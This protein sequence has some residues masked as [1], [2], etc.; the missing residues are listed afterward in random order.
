MPPS[1]DSA[2]VQLFS[3]PVP[4]PNFPCC[5][6][7]LHSVPL[8]VPLVKWLCNVFF[9]LP[10][11]LTHFPPLLHVSY[12]SYVP[13]ESS[14]G[15]SSLGVSLPQ[16]GLPVGWLQ[17]WGLSMLW[18]GSSEHHTPSGISLLWC[19][20]PMGHNLFRSVPALGRGFSP[21]EVPPLALSTYF[22]EYIY[23]HIPNT[24]LFHVSPPFLLL[25][26]ISTFLWTCLFTYILMCLLPSWLHLF[27][28][29]IEQ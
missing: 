25:C 5:H 17:S 22:Q 6:H 29:T 7:M 3:F 24:V 2:S 23:S 1:P 14:R 13:A 15:C 26:F 12:C 4:R 27:L 16:H 11:L 19:G 28:N 20:L 9:L 8:P 10:L 18:C 21:P